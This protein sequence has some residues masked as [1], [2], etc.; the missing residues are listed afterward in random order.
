MLELEAVHARF[1]AAIAENDVT[2]WGQ[3]N[4]DFHMMLYARAPLPRTHAIVN[5]LLQISD[6]YTRMQLS[7]TEYMGRAEREHGELI[8][9][10]RSKKASEAGALLARHIE[11]VRT[12]LLRVLKR[13]K[14]AL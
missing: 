13:T 1:V 5:S 2:Q 4:A 11:T 14:L 10:C 7:T 6:R 9:L 12:D 3:L 8:A